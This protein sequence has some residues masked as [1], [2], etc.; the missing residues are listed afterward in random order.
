M[1]V[2]KVALIVIAAAAAVSVP[3]VMS[4]AHSGTDL[5]IAIPVAT[6]G[7]VVAGGCVSRIRRIKAEECWAENRAKIHPVEPEGRG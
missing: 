4:F 7:C 3:V 6:I 1:K 5:P 2:K